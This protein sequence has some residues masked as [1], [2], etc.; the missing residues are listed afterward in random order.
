M[1]RTA[2]T[3]AIICLSSAASAA[4]YAVEFNGYS[5]Q[6]S[7]ASV[8]PDEPTQPVTDFAAKVCAS[9][10]KQPAFQFGQPINSVRSLFFYLC[11]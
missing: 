2:L 4:P 9:V 8:N 1:R 3:F 11:L 5:V 10:G 6:I 7:H